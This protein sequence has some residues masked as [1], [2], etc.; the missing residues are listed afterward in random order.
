MIKW[1]AKI[2]KTYYA[3]LQWNR[4]SVDLSKPM[5]LLLK[6]CIFFRSK[7]FHG[8]Q[9]CLCMELLAQLGDTLAVVGDQQCNVAS[10][11]LKATT[12]SFRLFAYIIKSVNYLLKISCACVLGGTASET[13]TK[14]T[15][16]TPALLS[17]AASQ[18][19]ALTKVSGLAP[20]CMSILIIAP[21]TMY[22]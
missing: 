7:C 5:G 17:M 20:Q 6:I 9:P 22:S 15:H 2:F 3:S 8:L 12:K 1:M 21:V 13:E 11:L 19:R 14:T 4:N 18:S 16:S 10:M